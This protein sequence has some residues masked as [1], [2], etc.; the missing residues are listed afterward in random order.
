MLINLSPRII[1]NILLADIDDF[2]KAHFKNSTIAVSPIMTHERGS[3]N[4]SILNSLKFTVTNRSFSISIFTGNF[5][6]D[7]TKLLKEHI[8]SNLYHTK[9]VLS[10]LLRRDIQIELLERDNEVIA[11]EEDSRNVQNRIDISIS[12]S[13]MELYL[14]LIIPLEFFRF[15]SKKIKSAWDTDLIETELL[16]FFRKPMKIFPSIKVI[17]ATFSN[18]ELQKLFFQ[19]QNKN[20]LTTYQICLLVQSFPEHSI[21][22][23]NCL[24]SNTTNDI[25]SMMKILRE[26]DMIKTRDLVEGIY[27]IEE[28]VFI[29]MKKGDDFS[30]SRFLWE[31]Q[32]VLN[33]FSNAQTLLQKNFSNWV[34]DMRESELLYKTISITKEVDIARSISD[35]PDKFYNILKNYI[36]ERRMNEIMSLII[37]RDISYS[38]RIA[39]QFCIISNYRRLKI[40]KMSSKFRSFGYLLSCIEDPDDFIYILFEAGWFTLSTACKEVKKKAIIPL[41]NS[42]PLPARYLIEDVLSGVVNPNIIHDEIQIQKART[43]CIDKIIS[44][45]E[46]GVIHLHE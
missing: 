1:I 24:S 15:F 9:V 18:Y 42:V 3:F 10:I 2:I 38:E 14:S 37:N 19:L 39:S 21:Q 35:S 13:D 46:D 11:Y 28:A 36:S 32:K 33:I 27:S 29:L 23:K 22:I 45:Y 4:Y 30:Y 6:S 44:L 41:L 25:K 8:K 16:I 12:T 5:P 34:E 26:K 40:S 20:L 43:I 31:I 7:K 17:F